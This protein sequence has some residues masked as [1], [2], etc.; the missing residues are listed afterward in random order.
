TAVPNLRSPRASTCAPDQLVRVDLERWRSSL[1]AAASG[2]AEQQRLLEQLGLGKVPGEG[3]P[4][5][6]APCLS[7][8]V[9]RGVD[10]LSAPL[11]GEESDDKLVQARF[12]LCP[13]D[14][15]H[16]IVSLRIQVLQPDGPGRFCRL[17]SELSLDQ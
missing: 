11:S 3:L 4:L 16:R 7:R 1:R 12:E 6:E 5:E 2:S 17:G 8:P 14:P 13:D 15:R 10:V 9:A